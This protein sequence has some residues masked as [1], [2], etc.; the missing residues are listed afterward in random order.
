LITLAGGR[1]LGGSLQLLAE[2]FSQSRLELD[3]L[4]R[5]FGE[6]H[7]GP[8]SQIVLGGLEGGLFGAGVLGALVL[9]S[10]LSP[11]RHSRRD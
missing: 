8:F 2:S 6:L 4:G 1:L 3:A 11:R 7:F 5:F 9:A 10:G